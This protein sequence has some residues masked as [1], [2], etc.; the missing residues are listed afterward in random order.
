M[1]S[2]ILSTISSR[3]PL[4]VTRRRRKIYSQGELVLPDP[5][6]SVYL[7]VRGILG[8]QMGIPTRILKLYAF[9]HDQ[10]PQTRVYWWAFHYPRDPLSPYD[11]IIAYG[12][13]REIT[14]FLTHNIRL[15]MEPGYYTEQV[16]QTV[17]RIDT[18]LAKT[19]K[20]LIILAEA[21]RTHVVAMAQATWAKGI[22]PRG[23]V[24]RNDVRREEAKIPSPTRV[25]DFLR[26]VRQELATENTNV[27]MVDGSKDKDFESLEEDMF[28]AVAGDILVFF[29]YVANLPRVMSQSPVVSRLILEKLLKREERESIE[30]TETSGTGEGEVEDNRTES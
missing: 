24:F 29:S 26:E 5:A 23:N 10:G 14:R 8:P 12:D 28:T 19:P 27:A 13:S 16:A 9:D 6:T 25:G 3:G 30:E 2:G 7:L 1:I 21:P 20:T 4:Q 15:R 17:T 11:V 18:F 22:A